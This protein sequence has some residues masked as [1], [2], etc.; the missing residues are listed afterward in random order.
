MLVEIILFLIAAFIAIPSFVLAI[1]Q[2]YVIMY[3][4]YHPVNRRASVWVMVRHLSQVL[5]QDITTDIEE[6]KL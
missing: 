5:Y 6:M 4:L 3:N 2:L 1:W